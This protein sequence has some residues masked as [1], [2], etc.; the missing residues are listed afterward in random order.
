MKIEANFD[1][2]LTTGMFIIIADSDDGG[3]SVTN[4]AASVVERVS[5]LSG[6]IGKRRLYY[7]DSA[8]R[9]DELK[10][11]NEAFAGFAPCSDNQQVTFSEWLGGPYSR[12]SSGR[13]SV[14]ETR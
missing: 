11:K 7:R 3:R 13:H 12:H 14:G 4:D 8:G 9:Y 6:G 1:V 2:L 10:V 5:M